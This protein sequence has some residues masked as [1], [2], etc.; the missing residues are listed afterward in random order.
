MSPPSSSQTSLSSPITIAD[1]PSTA[2]SPRSWL[3]TPKPIRILFTYFPLRTLPANNLPAHTL[4]AP[5]RGNH[6]LFIW[7]SADSHDV[8]GHLIPSFNPTCLKWQTYMLMHGVEFRVAASNNH[9]S[10]SGA[11]P[12]I[13]PA[14]GSQEQRRKKW[15]EK[16]DI[17][18]GSTV[19]PTSGTR[20]TTGSET[21]PS[22]V[23]ASG[24]QPWIHE[25]SQRPLGPRNPSEKMRCEAYVSLIEHR[26]RPAW[27]SHG[28]I[29][30][31][32]SFKLP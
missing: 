10:P 11:L 9:A 21:P 27:V 13:I 22:P 29:K 12:F 6:T 15:F 28:Y 14:E 3:Q 32:H 24:L 5:A 25:Q 18:D 16:S 4:P 1:Y 17:K 8:G 23:T 26:I 7:T 30:V 20:D 2:S 19:T 31:I